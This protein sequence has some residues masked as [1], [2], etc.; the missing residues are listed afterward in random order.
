MNTVKQVAKLAGISRRTLHYYDHIGLL[1][2][3]QVTT[4]GYRLYGQQDL[5]KLQQIL[6]FKE[7]GFSL[8]QIKK[9]MENPDFDIQAALR[10][11]LEVLELKKKRLEKLIELMERR[12]K[13]ELDM[14]FKEFGTEEINAAR[15]RYQKE[16][17]EKWGHTEAYRQSMARTKKYSS[18]DWTRINSEA[19]HIYLGLAAKMDR[20]PDSKEV[21]D[22][23]SR[24]QQHISKYYYDCSL[25]VLAGLGQAYVSDA[26]FTKNIDKYGQG[27]A[28]FMSKAIEA[29]VATKQV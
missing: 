12:L 27:L 19:E 22:L 7:M 15:E 4:A 11:Q 20:P 9:I 16:A 13:G 26:R 5:E 28:A 23:I 29:F 25:D 24:W 21:M 2:P 6:F 14:S 1:V 10:Q 8:D 18:S 17:E 3:Q